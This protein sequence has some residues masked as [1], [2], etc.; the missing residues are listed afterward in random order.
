MD[1]IN[2]LVMRIFAM[3]ILSGV[4]LKRCIICIPAGTCRLA[5]HCVKERWEGIIRVGL[6]D[7]VRGVDEVNHEHKIRV[8]KRD[9]HPGI[10]ERGNVFRDLGRYQCSSLACLARVPYGDE[11]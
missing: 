8:L 7:W 3:V 2:F 11:L 5:R 6:D 10:F 1:V 9:R 4:L